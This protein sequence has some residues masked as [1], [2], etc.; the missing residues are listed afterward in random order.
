MNYRTIIGATAGA[1]AL[2]GCLC[3]MPAIKRPY[4]LSANYASANLSDRKILV[5]MPGD[6]NILINNKDDV[7]DDYG[8]ANARPE[9]RIRKYYFP[10]FFQ[11]FKSLASGDSVF[12][13]DALRPD[14]S[15]DSLSTGATTLK[16]GG[17]SVPVSYAVPPKPRMQAAGLDNAVAVIIETI[18]F[19]RNNLY[20]E[21]YWDEKSRRPANLEVDA[22]VLIWDYK[23]DA[24]VFY[25]PLSEHIEFHFGL[26]RKHWDESADALARR[27]IRAAQ[28]L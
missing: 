7:I 18:E 9:A 21:Y 1:L 5:V 23:A 19:K 24:P 8:G 4:T 22:M 12:L 10:E 17:D 16:T 11:T 15:W 28:C 2:I 6:R 14:L 25:G 20:I 27:I 26:Q 13:F 3:S